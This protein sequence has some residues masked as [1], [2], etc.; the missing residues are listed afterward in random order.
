P[1]TPKC[2]PI[3]KEDRL[4]GQIEVSDQIIRSKRPLIFLSLKGHFKILNMKLNLTWH[5]NAV[6]EHAHG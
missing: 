1:K 6:L 2:C 5:V 3:N 4:K